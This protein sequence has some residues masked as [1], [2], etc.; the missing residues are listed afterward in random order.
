MFLFFY[1][2]GKLFTAHR[3]GIG[4]FGLAADII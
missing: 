3:H 4:L 2:V 1:S